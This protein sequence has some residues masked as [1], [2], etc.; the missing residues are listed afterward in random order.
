MS[1]AVCPHVTCPTEIQNWRVCLQSSISEGSVDCICNVLAIMLSGQWKT[2]F[3]SWITR[4]RRVTVNLMQKTACS[5]RVCETISRDGESKQAEVR[6]CGQ[7]E[8]TGGGW[9]VHS[10]YLCLPTTFITYTSIWQQRLKKVI[11]RKQLRE[12]QQCATTPHYISAGRACILNSSCASPECGIWLSEG[13]VTRSQEGTTARPEDAEPEEE[14]AGWRGGGDE[15][16]QFLSLI[17]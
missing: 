4:S 1:T 7:C 12:G 14:N 9:R 5:Q 6:Q 10:R 3:S 2:C 16:G 17:F 11:N 15:W 8:P 13:K